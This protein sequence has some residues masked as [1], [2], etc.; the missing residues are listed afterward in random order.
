[1]WIFKSINWKRHM[2]ALT[3]LGVIAVIIAIS[4]GFVGLLGY[5]QVAYPVFFPWFLAILGIF[6]LYLIFWA[7]AE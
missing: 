3:C 5:M 1:M 7:L 4:I 6:F 2:F